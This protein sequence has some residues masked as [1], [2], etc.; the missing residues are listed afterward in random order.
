[1]NSATPPPLTDAER[2]ALRRVVGDMI[3]ASREFGVPAA[4]DDAIFADLL[5]TVA[6]AIGHVRAALARLDELAGGTYATLDV[7]ARKLAAAQFREDSPALALLLATLTSRCYY[8]DDRVMR[9]LGMEVRP[10]FPKGFQVE[11]GDWSLLDAVRSR[12]KIYRDAP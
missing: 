2:L 12:P 9:S 7:D 11:P 10:P 6:P 5:Q 8:R 4:D 3:P 1:M